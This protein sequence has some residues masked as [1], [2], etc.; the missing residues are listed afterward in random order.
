M[1]E[2]S[3]FTVKEFINDYKNKH[4]IIYVKNCTEAINKLAEI[5]S[6]DYKNSIV[7]STFMEHHSNDLPWRKNFNVKYIDIDK[8]GCLDIADLKRKLN[9]YGNKISL[10]VLTGASNVTGSINSIHEIASLAHSFGVKV[11]VDGAQLEIGRAHV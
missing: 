3:R 7:L 6:Y 9:T 5:W 8:N 10:L 1:Y 11:L 4:D 2:K